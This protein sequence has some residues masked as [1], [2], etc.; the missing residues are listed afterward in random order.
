MLVKVNYLVNGTVVYSV[1]ARLD[2]K[3]IRELE[4]EEN[5]V[6]RAI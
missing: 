1:K 2:E 6:V 5:V 4:S 3:A